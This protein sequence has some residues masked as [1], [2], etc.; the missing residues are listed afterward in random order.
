MCTTLA[1]FYQD[2]HRFRANGLT[3]KRKDETEK[4]EKNNSYLRFSISKE[5]L[6]RKEITY[7]AHGNILGNWNCAISTQIDFVKYVTE[8]WKR[9]GSADIQ[10]EE[11][12][13]THFYGPFCSWC[14]WRWPKPCCPC[15]LHSRAS[16]QLSIAWEKSENANLMFCFFSLSGISCLKFLLYFVIFNG[17][18]K[19]HM[20]VWW[21]L[22]SGCYPRKMSLDGL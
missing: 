6:G 4:K 22:L 8:R 12:D 9:K 16:V 5:F 2:Q 21:S 19:I 15:W 3:E 7:L 13:V 11:V 10:L 20:H 17:L 14:S 1:K 18:G